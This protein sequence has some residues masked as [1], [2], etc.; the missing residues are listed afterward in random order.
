MH[1]GSKLFGLSAP[2]SNPASGETKAFSVVNRNTFTIRFTGS[3]VETLAGSGAT[4]HCAF[5]RTPCSKGR[6]L[7]KEFRPFLSGGGR[8]QTGSGQHEDLVLSHPTGAAG[9][10]GN[11]KP[12]TLAIKHR[13]FGSVTRGVEALR[14]VHGSVANDRFMGDDNRR[15]SQQ[16]IVRRHRKTDEQNARKHAGRGG[17]TSQRLFPRLPPSSES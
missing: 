5:G 6:V 2:E 14:F 3:L 13:Q 15:L 8:R 4:V 17:V 10:V 1:L 16:A 7:R 11:L 12:V 9:P